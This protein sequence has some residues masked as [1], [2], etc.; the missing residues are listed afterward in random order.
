MSHK[1]YQRNSYIFSILT[2]L[3]VGIVFAII[4]LEVGKTVA[5]YFINKNPASSLAEKESESH[6]SEESDED[7]SFISR[8]SRV[9]I[10]SRKEDQVALSNPAGSKVGTKPTLDAR[11][12][13]AKSYIVINLDKNNVLLEKDA[14]RLLPIASITKLVTAV[15]AKK[16]LDENKSIEI[17]KSMINT[18][19]TSGNLRLG[20][21]LKVKELFYPLLMVSSNDTAEA[22]ARAYGREKFIKE[23]NT[24]ASSIGAYK[25]YFEDPTGLSPKNVSSARD[26]S[27]I[28][29]WIMKNEPDLFDITLTKTKTIR[30]HTWINPTHFLNLDS[31]KGGKNG[32]TTEAKLTNVSLFEVGSPPEIYSVVL[33][34]SSLRDA[35]TM[36]AL[37]EALK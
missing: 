6:I 11:K 36:D 13:T 24:W 34:G 22:L 27:I 25:T 12:I 15:I 7:P 31:Y 5:N 29:N 30:A 26:I 10:Y 23:M 32:F 4:L 20:E 2:S 1:A 28:A 37:Q 33:L 8:F 3:I 21:K 16:L 9:F 17:T 14:D 35:D 19:G 18:E